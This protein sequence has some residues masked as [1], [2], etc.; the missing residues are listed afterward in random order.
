MGDDR[1]PQR[2]RVWV[3]VKRQWV[4]TVVTISGELE[5]NSTK[6]LYTFLTCPPWP[7][8]KR[9]DEMTIGRRGLGLTSTFSEKP[10][11]DRSRVYPTTIFACSQSAGQS[12][13][14]QIADFSC[15]RRLALSASSR[16]HGWYVR[17]DPVTSLWTRV[18]R[19]HVI[20]AARPDIASS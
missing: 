1:E 15:H 6:E 3:I 10:G 5:I 16:A 13:D 9:C 14:W 20:V 7:A 17:K 18:Y 8:G 19:R 12:T 2:Y 4:P 11:F